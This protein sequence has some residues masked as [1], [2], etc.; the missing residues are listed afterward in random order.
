[1]RHLLTTCVIFVF[2]P[3]LLSNTI[4]DGLEEIH[5]INHQTVNFCQEKPSD[6]SVNIY[7]DLGIRHPD[8]I[9]A[10]CQEQVRS[11]SIFNDDKAKESIKECIEFRKSIVDHLISLGLNCKNRMAFFNNISSQENLNLDK[12]FQT[13]KIK[14]SS[15]VLIG[16]NHSELTV[17]KQIE[18]FKKLK[19]Y[20][21]NLDCIFLE[22]DSY[23]TSD[24]F[25]TCIK[26]KKCPEKLSFRNNFDGSISNI[27]TKYFPIFN[28]LVSFAIENNLQIYPVDTRGAEP[29]SDVRDFEMGANII[30][31]LSDKSCKMGVYSVGKSHLRNLPT[32]T[33]KLISILKEANIPYT[34]LNTVSLNYKKIDQEKRKDLISIIGWHQHSMCKENPTIN[35]SKHQV[36]ASPQDIVMINPTLG[37]NKLR[38]MFFNEFDY[39]IFIE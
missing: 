36:A 1:M 5:R 22:L 10:F 28:E 23:S 24:F 21:S 16:E 8:E 14:D 20:N 38:P 18:I 2:S 15:L 3:N 25:K 17:E 34:S 32:D 12:L 29:F 33:S 9:Q 6:K 31:H 26:E 39:T 30:K 27:E 35:I 37:K 4:L 19:E 13:N 7:E 11:N